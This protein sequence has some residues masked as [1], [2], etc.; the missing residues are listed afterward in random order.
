[1]E[2]KFFQLEVTV[3]L[4]KDHRLVLINR[5]K[6]CKDMERFLKGLKKGNENDIENVVIKSVNTEIL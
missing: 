2:T 5:F 1:M 6:K 3:K 4:R